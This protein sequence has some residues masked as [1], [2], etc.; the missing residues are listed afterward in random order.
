MALSIFPLTPTFVE[1][2]IYGGL[3][4]SSAL[5]IEPH[6]TSS[7]IDC[8]IG[9]TQTKASK[10]PMKLSAL[11]YNGKRHVLT[12]RTTPAEI[13]VSV[14]EK[15]ATIIGPVQEIG[16]PTLS[17]DRR[18]SQAVAALPSITESVPLF[19][20]QPFAASDRF[21]S[22]LQEPDNEPHRMNLTTA[23]ALHGGNC[24]GGCP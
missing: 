23:Q 20:G 6:M 12:M 4:T 17:N 18:V 7:R 2:N 14:R 13:R 11:P 16:K 21:R 22:T 8:A 5:E 19:G 15:P 1:R 10:Q 9:K 24:P 3:V